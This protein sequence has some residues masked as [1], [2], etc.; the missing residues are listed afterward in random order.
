MFGAIGMEF[1]RTRGRVGQDVRWIVKTRSFA[2]LGV[3]GSVKTRGFC[4]SGRMGGGLS[5]A[6]ENRSAASKFL[7]R[8]IITYTV[9]YP[10]AS[11]SEYL[12]TRGSV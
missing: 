7:F 5:F 8:C 2:G 1:V 9:I 11:F 10:Y 12:T 6:L 4:G 3:G